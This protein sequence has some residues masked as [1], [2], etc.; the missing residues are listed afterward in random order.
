MYLLYSSFTGVGI[1]VRASS[2]KSSLLT[3]GSVFC[4]HALAP[5]S[6]ACRSLDSPPPRYGFR[7]RSVWISFVSKNERK[8]RE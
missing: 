6:W 2:A 7:I 5:L 8:K 4:R 3:L 1:W